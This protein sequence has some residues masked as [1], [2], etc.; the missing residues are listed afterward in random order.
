M[1]R[2]KKMTEVLKNLRVCVRKINY[3]LESSWK[4]VIQRNLP[5]GIY[6]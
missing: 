3:I 1:Q 5:T 2:S 4:G 6:I